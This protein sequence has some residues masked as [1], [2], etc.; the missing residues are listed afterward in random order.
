MDIT[1]AVDLL[2]YEPQDDLTE[3]NDELSKLHLHDVLDHALAAGQK[4]GLREDV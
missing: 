4:S 2:G 1:T 3:I